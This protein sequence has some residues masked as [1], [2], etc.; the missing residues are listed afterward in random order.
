M[1]SNIYNLLTY[2]NKI[3]I[4]N[5]KQWAISIINGR[6]MIQHSNGMSKLGKAINNATN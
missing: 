6:T 2:S 1:P 5:V 4:V 3:K